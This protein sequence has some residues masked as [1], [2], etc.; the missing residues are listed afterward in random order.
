MNNN[1]NDKLQRIIQG[2]AVGLSV[3]LI[4]L[5]AYQMRLNNDIIANHINESTAVMRESMGVQEKLKGTVDLLTDS[6]DDLTGF[7]MLQNK[8]R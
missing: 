8:D 2:G 1:K 3:A 7:L 6:I 5:I 4:I